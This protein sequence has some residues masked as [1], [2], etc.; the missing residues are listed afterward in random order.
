MK[1]LEHKV[2]NELYKKVRKKEIR[3]K[4]KIISI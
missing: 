2:M 1:G 4:N 3:N